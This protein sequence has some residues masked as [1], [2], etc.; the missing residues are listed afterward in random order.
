MEPNYTTSQEDIMV[1]FCLTQTQGVI[2]KPFR[3]SRGQLCVKVNPKDLDLLYKK[4][5]GLNKKVSLGFNLDIPNFNTTHL[6]DRI[7]TIFHD[8]EIALYRSFSP[9]TRKRLI[10]DSLMVFNEDLTRCA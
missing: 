4:I 2:P 3:D 5:T 9:A 10:A 6:E 7:Y 8:Y 1:C